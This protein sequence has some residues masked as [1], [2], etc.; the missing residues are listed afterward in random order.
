MATQTNTLAVQPSPAPRA[1]SKR[2]PAWSTG[3]RRILASAKA[4]REAQASERAR[5]RDELTVKLMPL[6]KRVAFEMKEHLPAHLDVDDLVSAGTLGLVDAVRKFE[7]GKQVKIETYARYRIR[8]AILDA[9]REVDPA[10]RDMRRKIKRAE[11]VFRKLELKFGRPPSDAEMAEALHMNLKAWYQMVYEMRA[12]G[13]EWL[14]PTNMEAPGTPN[15]EDL[16][17]STEMGQFELCYRREQRDLLNRS[18]ACVS[19][20]D[21]QI[22]SMYYEQDLT[23]KQI[24]ERLDLD[25]SRVSQIHSMALSRL[26]SSVQSMMRAPL[27]GARPPEAGP[28]LF[29]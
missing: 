26:R 13:L 11:Q 5:H 29:G 19:E 17:A 21:R 8:G 7:S 24:A 9:L 15:E 23:M 1:T 6:V 25:E 3:E 2:R 27:P 18:L 16:P 20:R 14:R 4:H 10:S 12:G 28:G 22:L